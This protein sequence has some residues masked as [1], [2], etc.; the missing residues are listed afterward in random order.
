MIITKRK[1]EQEVQKRIRKEVRILDLETKC[2]IQEKQI[3]RIRKEMSYLQKLIAEGNAQAAAPE[4]KKGD[5]KGYYIDGSTVIP[6]GY[7]HTTEAQPEG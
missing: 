5:I 1:F 3:R 6:C 7:A 2:R 4:D